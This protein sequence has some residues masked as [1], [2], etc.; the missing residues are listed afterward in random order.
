MRAMDPDG[1]T[2]REPDAHR[3]HRGVLVS[4]G[5]HHEWSC[6]GHDKLSQIGFPI[7]GVRDKWSGKWLA[8]WVVP[9]NRY[10]KVIAY[11]YLSLIVLLGGKTLGAFLLASIYNIHGNI[12]FRYAYTKY[13]RLRVGNNSYVWIGDI[14]KVCLILFMNDIY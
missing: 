4:L 7:W 3:V 9:N 6:D 11:L 13:N 8:L 10:M 5:P 14:L 12:Y 2:M 1:F